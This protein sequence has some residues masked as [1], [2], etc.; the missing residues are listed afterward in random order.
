[1]DFDDLISERVP[2]ANRAGTH[3]GKFERHLSEGAVIVAYAMHLIRTEAVKTITISP[4]GEHGKRFQFREWFGQQGFELVASSGN[5]TYGGRYEDAKGR[6]LTVSLRPGFGDV[7]AELVDGTR[8]IAEC[9]GGVVSSKHA[10]QLSRL[11]KG[12]CEVVGQ[13]MAAPAEGRQVAVVPNTEVTA[14]LAEKLAPRCRAAGIVIAL[15]G[16]RG[17]VTDVA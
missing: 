17:E 8:I 3:T 7:A 15:V 1:M 14:R 6:V 2:P 9:K 16:D 12:L 4:D 5:T 10:G 11:R 13:L